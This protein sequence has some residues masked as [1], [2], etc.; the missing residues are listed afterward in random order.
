M[1]NYTR[2]IL[3]FLFVTLITNGCT[4]NSESQIKEAKASM[5]EDG[6][7]ALLETSSNVMAFQLFTDEMPISTAL[8]SGLANGSI[9][10]DVSKIGESVYQGLEF[11]RVSKNRILKTGCPENN[12]SEDAGVRVPAEESTRKHDKKG[13]LTM[14]TNSSNEIGSQFV[15]T[16][17]PLNY[18][19]KRG[20]IIGEVIYGLKSSSKIQENDKIVSISIIESK[21]GKLSDY[22]NGEEFQSQLAAYK[23]QKRSDK[24]NNG[25]FADINTNK[26]NILLRLEFEKTPITV[27][28]FVGLAE[29]KIENNKKPIGTP[30]YDGLI[31]HRVIAD[32]MIQGGCPLGTGTGDPGYKF[33]DEF[34]S[35]LK[36][37]G[38]GILSMANSGPRTNGSQFFI[39]HKATTWLDGKHTVF[40][41]VIEGMEVVNVIKKGD[42]IIKI[43][44]IRKGKKAEAFLPT[45]KSFL[46]M[47][48]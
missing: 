30:Y 26:G 10:N 31:F 37:S 28:N 17:A 48:K 12:G 9:K 32:F 34:D 33:A 20:V 39:T 46:K 13:L 16:L 47:I 40:G 19:D 23:K 43:S 15:I 45:N 22:N 4:K 6:V 8:F 25:L 27:A 38:P 14:L 41:N 5:I 11:F 1:K 18:M 35:T 29:G 3:P 44:I 24:I 42:K 36:H 2:F 21:G 7:Y